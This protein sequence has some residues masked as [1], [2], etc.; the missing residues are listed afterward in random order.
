MDGS[1]LHAR[2]WEAL[3]KETP[4]AVTHSFRPLKQLFPAQEYREVF[5]TQSLKLSLMGLLPVFV[6]HVCNTPLVPIVQCQSSL[7]HEIR[8]GSV[9]PHTAPLLQDGEDEGQEEGHAFLTS[10]SAHS[11]R[12]SLE[13]NQFFLHRFDSSSLK[14]G[15]HNSPC[16]DLCF[17]ASQH[18]KSPII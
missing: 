2:A 8:C 13:Q 16:S 7:I 3:F 1:T 12:L 10:Y 15:L 6:Q 11:P 14:E 17:S 4:S 18:P 9:Q 5:V